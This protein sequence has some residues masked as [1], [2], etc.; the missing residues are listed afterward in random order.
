MCTYIFFFLA[1]IL[2]II[3]QFWLMSG[4]KKKIA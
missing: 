3:E 2:E 1:F 4:E